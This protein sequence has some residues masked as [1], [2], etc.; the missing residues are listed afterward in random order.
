MNRHLQTRLPFSVKLGYGT[1]EFSST[2]TWTLVSVVFLFFLTDVVGLAPVFAGFVMMLGGLWDAVTDPTMGILSDRLNHRWGRRRPFLLAVALPFG[3]ITWLLL[4]DFGFGPVATKVYFCLAIM[5]Y[6]TAATMLDVPYTSL[7][8]EMTQDYDERTSLN[9][10]RALFSQIAAIVAAAFPWTLV[11]FCIDITGDKKAGWSLMAGIFGITTIL[12]ILITWHTSRGRE[13]NIEKP[14]I[15][16]KDIFEG[17]LKNRTFLYTM[18]IYI[19]GG[20]SLSSAGAVMIYFM[21]Y[22]MS[23]NGLQESLAFLFLFACSIIWI[24]VIHLLSARFGKRESFIFFMGIWAVVQAAGVMMIK[25]GMDLAFYTMM[26]IA[27]GGVMSISMT[28]WAM[29]PDAIEVDEFKTGER[30]EGLYFGV[31]AFSRKIA[32]AMASLL[33]GLVLSAVGY[34][35]NQ[36][37][38]ETALMGIRI[39]YAEGVGFFVFLS[40]I[41]AYLL[42]MNRRRHRAL[43]EAIRAQKAGMAYDEDALRKIL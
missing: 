31:I 21:K 9:G 43:R 24:P 2:L 16:L 22:Y 36:P 4:T 5:A 42:P 39:L 12:P 10:Y 11:A 19:C 26:F 28:I 37:Q 14:V 32:V 15:R 29:I 1:A 38:T 13:L 6:Y 30:R 3:L 40:V 25:P 34:V 33:I 7:G 18:G 35:E 17:P 20:V 23:F 41:M 27:S 8:A